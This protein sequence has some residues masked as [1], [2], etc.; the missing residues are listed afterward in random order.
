M[1]CVVTRFKPAVLPTRLK[2]VGADELGHDQADE[3]ARAVAPDEHG[4]GGEEHLR[5]RPRHNIAEAHRGQ[6]DDRP[7]DSTRV[8]RGR[9]AVYGVA[10]LQPGYA[11]LAPK[12]ITTGLPAGYMGSL[13]LLL[14]GLK[15]VDSLIRPV[16]Q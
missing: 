9:P 7:V 10:G 1:R 12:Y 13:P 3:R 11:G 16:D 14:R 5:D 6:C 8:Q 2:A 4:G 15:S